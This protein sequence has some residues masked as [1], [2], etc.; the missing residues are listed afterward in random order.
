MM[1]ACKR[2]GKLSLKYHLDV[3]RTQE[4]DSRNQNFLGS[5]CPQPLLEGRAYSAW[6]AFAH[7]VPMAR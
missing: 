3:T 2:Y 1:S 5:A 4:M 7:G 6:C